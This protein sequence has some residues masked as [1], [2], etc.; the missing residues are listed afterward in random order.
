MRREPRCA[1]AVGELIVADGVA[2]LRSETDPRSVA[3]ALARHRPFL[4]Q[5]SEPLP[6][7][8]LEA[9]AA[10]LEQLYLVES[11]PKDGSLDL[12]A[13]GKALRHLV[14][15]D[16]YPQQEIEATD[17]VFGGETLWCRGTS[18]RGDP[19]RS[20]VDVRWR[21]PVEEYLSLPAAPGG[22]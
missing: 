1:A 20:N 4:L 13:R 9:A 8:L 15:G 10:A 18:L 19:E 16:H 21:R 3:P 17:A 7:R 22:S 5:F 11:K 6:E 14:V 12:V 2:Q